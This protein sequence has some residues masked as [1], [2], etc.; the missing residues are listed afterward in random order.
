VE[1]PKSLSSLFTK[2]HFET[3]PKILIPQSF[4]DTRGSISN[5]ADG[6]LGDVA[7]IT[8]K[9]TSIRANH[10]HENDWHLSYLVTGQMKYFWDDGLGVNEVLVD[11][12]EMFYTPPKT[13][14][15]MEFLK[16]SIFIAVSYLSR[17][18]E[19]YDEDTRKL[20]IDYFKK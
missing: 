3:Y 2:V 10:I 20:P 12:G 13:P 16:D 4:E 15:K 19:K 14:H 9:N 18:Q 6:K 11:A 1:I 8:S 17:S 7:V 5:I